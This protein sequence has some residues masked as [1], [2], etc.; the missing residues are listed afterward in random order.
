MVLS[1]SHDLAELVELCVARSEAAHPDVPPT[2]RPP[3]VV[4]IDGPAGAGKT[5]LSHH[6]APHLTWEDDSGYRRE[7]TI[8]HLDDLY[9]GWADGPAGGAQ[10]V[11]EQVLKPLAKRK[12]GRYHR[13]DWHRG[14]F[15]EPHDV[16]PAPFVIVEGSGAGAG[17]A[18]V[19]KLAAVLIWL[20]A[21]DSERIARV[22]ARDGEE[23]REELEAW[24]DEEQRHFAADGTRS[25][26]DVI[27]RRDAQRGQWVLGEN[28]GQ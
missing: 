17:V 25:R 18:Q 7:A 2:R 15:A 22:L 20:D 28:I 9:N 1:R 6:L 13:Y 27:L 26:A 14:A 16:H 12:S 11:A 3:L 5:T 4:A 8:V 24:V 10:R 23:I 21:D 19:P